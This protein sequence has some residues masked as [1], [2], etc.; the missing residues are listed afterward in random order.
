MATIKDIAK[1][2]G[3][4]QG[5]VSNVLNGRDI[6][7]SDK[8]QRVLKAIEETGYVIN[9]K[10]HNLRKGTAKVLAVILPN[11]FDR[12]YLDFF[13]S[14]RQ[15]AESEGYTVDLYTTNDDAE[16]EKKIAGRLRSRMTEGIAVYSALSDGSNPYREVGFPEDS[17]L[18]VSRRQP[19]ESMYIGFD[20]AEAGRQMAGAAAQKEYTQ[21]A[22]LTGTLNQSSKGAFHDAFVKT[23]N[24]LMPKCGVYVRTTSSCCRYKNAIRLFTHLPAPQAVFT[25]NIALAQIAQSV[26]HNFFHKQNLDIYTISPVFSLPEDRYCKY[27]FDYRYLGKLSAKRLIHKEEPEPKV[28]ILPAKGFSR[29]PSR[30][31]IPSGKVLSVATIG[32]PTSRA[33][34]SLVNLYEDYS[35]TKV[36]LVELSGNTLYNRL[37]AWGENTSYDIV[38]LDVNWLSWFAKKVFEPLERIDCTIREKL[39]GFLPDIMEKYA[40][41]NGV[42]YAFPGTPCVQ[43]LFYRK[44]LFENTQLKRQYFDRYKK[45]LAPPVTFEE[46][47]RVAAFF[48]GSLNP[49]SPVKYGATLITGEADVAGMEFLMRYF[50]HS[51]NLFD[52]DGN[53]ML[54]SEAGRQSFK[55]LLE[56]YPCTAPKPKKWWLDGAQEFAR[57]ETAMTIQFINHVS[58][59][60]GPDSLVADKIGWAMVPGGNPMLGGSVLGVSKYSKQKEEALDFLKWISRDDIATAN[61]LLGGMS[62][63]AASYENN[64]VVDSYPWLPFA[65]GCFGKSQMNYYL[66]KKEAPFEIRHLQTV[67]GLAVTEV[68]NN[69]MT[70]EEAVE[71]AVSSL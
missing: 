69:S 39:S 40:E 2:A 57:G 66:S 8:L 45:Q 18:F 36:R 33:L 38:R 67:L 28:Q 7:G 65:Q 55:E 44:D 16:Y 12:P 25:E 42:L 1:A 5:T 14:F 13:A 53:L 59:F 64:E 37:T 62:A 29:W 54:H 32:S 22:L 43:L 24:E 49:N 17:I 50:S 47:C 20:Y 26:H 21:V 61:M 23:W 10:A 19:Y 35:G 60:V 34:Q 52:R 31:A 4:S 71:L 11:M 9:E 51:R 63:R 27:E 70:V 68:L 41:V 6:V 56:L 3:V 30:D 58:D 15:Y 46:Y 48:T